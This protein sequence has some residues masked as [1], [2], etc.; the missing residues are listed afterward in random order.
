MREF[1]ILGFFIGFL[2]IAAVDHL[3]NVAAQNLTEAHRDYIE[4]MEEK[5]VYPG[6]TIE[7]YNNK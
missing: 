5:G 2:T 4:R 7:E 1:I 6:M 3:N